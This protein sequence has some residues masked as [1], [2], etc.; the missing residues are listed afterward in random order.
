MTNT[1]RITYRLKQSARKTISIYVASDGKIEVLAPQQM[2]EAEIDKHVQAKAYTIYKYQAE[3]ALLKESAKNREYVGGESFLYLGRN[4]RLSID[5]SFDYI[6]MKDNRFYGPKA[7]EQ[8]YKQLFIDFYKKKAK[9]KL[10]KRI[11]QYARQMGL[12]YRKIRIMDLK[13]RWA[14]CN[15]LN[16]LNFHWKVM[17]GPLKIIDYIIVHELAHLKH[18]THTEA[19]WSMVDRVLP[20]YQERKDW[21]RLNGAGMDV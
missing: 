1:E 5:S 21:L 13:T 8:E 4:Y 2:E 20:D 17:L 14:S 16:D 7:S 9:E 12:Q 19:F 6:Q 15:E 10:P 3:F 11:K 18:P